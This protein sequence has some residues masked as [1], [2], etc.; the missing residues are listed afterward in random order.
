[1]DLLLSV[2][3][4]GGCIQNLT[5]ADMVSNFNED[6]TLNMP[7]ISACDVFTEI[8]FPRND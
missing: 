4:S 8:M 3:Y 5:D 6:V 7:F 1:M 2:S